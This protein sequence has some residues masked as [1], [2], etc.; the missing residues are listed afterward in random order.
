MIA[1]PHSD[2]RIT[3]RFRIWSILFGILLSVLTILPKLQAAPYTLQEIKLASLSQAEQI[4]LQFDGAYLDEPIVNFEPGAL[5][6][7]LVG[8]KIADG[9]GKELTPPNESLIRNVLVSQPAMAEFV[10]VDILFNSSRMAL[11]NPEV[12]REGNR[13]FL[14]LQFLNLVDIQTN[15]LAPSIALTDEVGERVRQADPFPS[16]F[17]RATPDPPAEQIAE[18]DKIPVQVA[19]EI[20]LGSAIP[21]QDWSSTLIGLLIA[22]FLI[23]ALIYGLAW[24]YGKFLSGKFPML[25]NQVNTRQV[26]VFHL[27]PKQKVVVLEIRKQLFACGV[28]PQSISLLAKLDNER[29]QTYLNALDLD[30][31]QVKIDHA[32]LDFLKTL[33]KAR[34]RANLNEVEQVIPETG[35][36]FAQDWGTKTEVTKTKEIPETE[37]RVDEWTNPRVVRSN[38]FAP[39]D[40]GYPVRTVDLEG[41]TI[42]GFAG[43]LTSRLKTLKPIR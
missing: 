2:K 37:S 4:S 3:N 6:V 41:S 22:L 33:E 34:Q 21:D 23:L 35:K 27:G 1:L 36:K 7:R 28:T 10:Q 14:D 20:E 42:E 9:L 29:D 32:R 17:S 16:T 38:V 25:E 12:W 30:G 5:S 39:I 40:A 31:G 8:T 26:S 11:G 13:M 18:L 24:V 19:T 15:T 43:K